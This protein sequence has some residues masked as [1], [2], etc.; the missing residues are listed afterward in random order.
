MA[1]VDLPEP[2]AMELLERRL[3]E[4]VGD[5]VERGLKARY[6]TI[7]A[8]ALLVAG[9]SGYSMVNNFVREMVGSSVGPVTK[10]AERTIAQMN[11]Q[12]DA[13]RETKKRL[14]GLVDEI[15]LSAEQAQRRIGDTQKRVDQMQGEFEGVLAKIQDQLST[16]VVRRRELEADI[17]ASARSLEE[18]L[19][20]TRAGLATVAEELRALA[21]R[22]PAADGPDDPALDARLAELVQ[23]TKAS[24]EAQPWTTVLM[25]YAAGTPIDQVQ[26]MARALRGQRYLL[27]APRSELIDAREVRWFWPEDREAAARVAADAARE[28]QELGFADAGF[29]LKDFSA[30]QGVKPRRG[31]IE[32]WLVLPAANPQGAKP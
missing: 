19:S 22:L 3:A 2:A 17:E 26:A 10:E 14:D 30:Y 25:Q 21:R 28:M 18:R 16:V 29:T 24:G 1:S 12:L 7:F 5:R 13:A 6:G 11:V 27:P 8:V 23:Q 20:D 9:F 32:L 4:S 15:S 31:T